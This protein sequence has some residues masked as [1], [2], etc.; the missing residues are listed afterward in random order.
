MGALPEYAPELP[1]RRPRRKR[2]GER[3]QEVRAR[4]APRLPKQATLP[5]PRPRQVTPT[6]ALASLAVVAGPALAAHLILSQVFKPQAGPQLPGSTA[7]AL[8]AQVG[9]L[10]NW[11]READTNTSR[12]AL[13]SRLQAIQDRLSGLPASQ[14]QL[15]S[16][17]ELLEL[18]SRLTIDL[19]TGGEGGRT[20]SWQARY[21]DQVSIAE[22]NLQQCVNA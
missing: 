7:S 17:N 16:R 18:N 8:L 12:S 19:A 10:Q 9:S 2:Y 22:R 15:L 21:K 20:P 5:Q 14:C 6:R 1:A 13:T 11:L 4:S 3:L